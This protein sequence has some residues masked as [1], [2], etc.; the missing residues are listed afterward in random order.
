MSYSTEVTWGH[1]E[2]RPDVKGEF[3]LDDVQCEGHES[4]LLQCGHRPFGEHNCE[5][6]EAAEV[7]CD[8]MRNNTGNISTLHPVKNIH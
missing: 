1:N 4:S 3:W 2:T 5:L 7:E 8:P 6:Q